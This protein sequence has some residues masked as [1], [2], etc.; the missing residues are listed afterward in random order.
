VLVV[1]LVVV[2]DMVVRDA[3]SEVADP[4]FG[5]GGGEGIGI[6]YD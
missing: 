4:F 6:N 5:R 1:G 2:V 3:A